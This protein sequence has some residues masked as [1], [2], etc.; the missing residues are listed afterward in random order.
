MESNVTTPV[1]VPASELRAE[2]IRRLEK[3]REFRG[4]LLA[5]A[6]VNVLLWAIWGVVFVVSGAWFPWPL[7]ALFGWGIG[8]AFHAWDAYGRLPFSEEEVQRE[9]ARLERR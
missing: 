3:K 4:H 6:M 9:Q 1:V 5:Y 8:L 2:A 7:F